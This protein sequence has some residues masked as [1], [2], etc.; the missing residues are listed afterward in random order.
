MGVKDRKLAEDNK[1]TGG[2]LQSE[3]TAMDVG[4]VNV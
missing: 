1:W 4:D 2:E 3:M